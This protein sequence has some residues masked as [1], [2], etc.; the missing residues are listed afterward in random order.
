MAMSGCGFIDS[1]KLTYRQVT[2]KTQADNNAV[3]SSSSSEEGHLF[4]EMNI[5]ESLPAPSFTNS[6][7]GTTSVMVGDSVELDGSATV[8]GGGVV[9][10]QWYISSVESNGGG[11]AIEGATDAVYSPDTSTA[12]TLYYYVVAT[13]TVGDAVN[14][15]VSPAHGVGVWSEGTWTKNDEENAYQY[16]ENDTGSFPTDTTLT[17]D[18]VTYKFDSNG[19]AVDDSGKYIDPTATS[20]SSSDQQNNNQ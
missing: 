15:S 3:V 14:M 19:F 16:V 11:T 12:G 6:L 5:D 10:Y 7:E 20:T 18:G 8:S 1:L 13:N 2:G 4:T 9:T 17:I